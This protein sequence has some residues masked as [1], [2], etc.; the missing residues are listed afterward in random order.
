[1]IKKKKKIIIQ[2]EKKKLEGEKPKEIR[3]MKILKRKRKTG[4]III[5]KKN[6]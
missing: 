4:K 5:R 2:N 6:D 3:K 1:M